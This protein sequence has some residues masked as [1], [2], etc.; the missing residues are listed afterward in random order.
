[1]KK[2]ALTLFVAVLF[3]T[4]MMAQGRLGSKLL[5][6]L[7]PPAKQEE[8]PQPMD[9]KTTPDGYSITTDDGTVTIEDAQPGD[10]QPNTFL[11]SFVMNIQSTEK[12]KTEKSMIEYHFQKWQTSM[13]PTVEGQQET[14]QMIFNLQN[15]KMTLLTTDKKGA[16]TGIITK[17][18]KVEF[19]SNKLDEKIEQ[20]I[21]NTTFKRTGEKKNIS[22]YTCEKWIITSPDGVSEAWI[23]NEI[24]FNMANAFNMFSAGSKGKGGSKMSGFG[25]ITGFALESTFT[26]NKGNV[27]KMTVSD[28]KVGNPSDTHFSTAGYTITDV[29]SF[30]SMFGK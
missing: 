29:S 20:S 14:M 11:G 16:K 22:G 4:Q 8:Q 12:G 28:I 30:G 26:D 21:D 1:M 18:P 24:D 27:S 17:M 15:Q 25:D 5:D 10:F 13:K 7:A 23:T 2:I 19:T 6:K 9:V 3:S